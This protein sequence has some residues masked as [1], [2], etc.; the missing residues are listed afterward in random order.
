VEVTEKIAQRRRQ[1]L[2][3]SL[4]YY[5]LDAPIIDDHSFDKWAKELAELQAEFPKESQAAPYYAEFRGF[6]GSTGADLDYD[7]P[8]IRDT[9]YRI[10]EF[11]RRKF[12]S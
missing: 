9:A 11:Y 1:I 2:V 3:H 8:E 6:D 10:T 12:R 7:R 5:G 4:L